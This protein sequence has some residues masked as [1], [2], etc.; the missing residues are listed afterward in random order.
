MGAPFLEPGRR[1][2]IGPRLPVGSIGPLPPRRLIG[3]IGAI[4]SG[5]AVAV[6]PRPQPR[7]VIA[8]NA[9]LVTRIDLTPSV[10]RFFVRPDAGVPPFEPGQ[11][12]ALGLEVDGTFLQR[13]YSTA[14]PSA[15]AAVAGAKRVAVTTD[16]LEFLVRRVA[17]GVFTPSLWSAAPGDRIWIGP[18]K[19]LFTLHPGDERTHLFVSSGTGLAPFISMADALLR[20]GSG[21]RVIVVHGASYVAELAYRDRLEGWAAGG[22][23]V[24]VPTI[25]RP[26]D[27]TNEG[28]RGRTGRAESILAP[29]CQWLGLDPRDSVAYL[30]GNPDMNESGAAVLAEVGFPAAAV[31]RELYWTARE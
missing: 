1:P 23:L 3:P 16:R 7:R 25:S 4:S 11:Y 28:W 27:P 17:G 29:V 6:I 22:R 26:S 15:T 31:V 5:S 18:P 10:A 19:G 30:C 20:S 14:S 24:Y 13:P 12:F 8:P 9:T 21:P 2:E